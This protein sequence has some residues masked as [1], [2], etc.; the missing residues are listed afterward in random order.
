MT[1]PG[2]RRGHWNPIRLT[3]KKTGEASNGGGKASPGPIDG[4]RGGKG[5]PRAKKRKTVVTLQGKNGAE[6]VLHAGKML[7]QRGAQR[8]RTRVPRENRGGFQAARR[9]GGEN[10]KTS[11]KKMVPRSGKQKRWGR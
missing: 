1:R 2:G 10:L 5:A 8:K 9:Q 7:V 4:R 6:G 11:K 3:G